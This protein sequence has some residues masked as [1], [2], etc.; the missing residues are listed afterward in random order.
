MFWPSKN[1]KVLSLLGEG[2]NANV[3]KVSKHQPNINI[4]TIFALKVLKRTEDLNHFKTEFESLLKAE[5]KHIVKYRGVEKYKSKPALLL[6]YI[7]GVTLH[8][9]LS[10]YALND[11]EAEW[12]YQ[13]TKAGLKELS[14]SKL[15]HGDLS[16]K[17]IMVTTQGNIK[18]IDF[19]LS[20]WRTKNIE[21]TPEFAAPSV[22]SGSQPSLESDVISLKRIFKQSNLKEHTLSEPVDLPSTLSQKIKTLQKHDF[23][24]TKA[25]PKKSKT[26]PKPLSFI[27]TRKNL[28][29]FAGFYFVLPLTIQNSTFKKHRLLVRS[30]NWLA[31]K[32]PNE[33]SWCFTPCNLNF[34]KTGL[35]EIHW[36]NSSGSHVSR[37]YID[38][39]VSTF[40]LAPNTAVGS[41]TN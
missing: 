36:K 5:G 16:P 20:H 14:D 2:L 32:T 35:H 38:G 10:Q 6:E 18:L 1:F 24:Q 17:N 30:S 22:L 4:S 21:V 11:H 28:F 23:Y 3:Y 29:I 9:L 13:E 25:L 33:K 26:S 7:N 19:G 15:F 40:K 37:I 12:I 31:V 41:I 39:H 34:K 8:T 27:N